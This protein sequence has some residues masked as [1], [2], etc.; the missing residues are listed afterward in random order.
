MKLKCMFRLRFFITNV[1]NSNSLSG[2][3]LSN[4]IHIHS[5]RNPMNVLSWVFSCDL[6]WKKLI[7]VSF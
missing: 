4:I 7:T 2:L 5:A 3:S 6:S 1:N